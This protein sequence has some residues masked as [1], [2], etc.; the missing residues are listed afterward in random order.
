MKETLFGD[1]KIQNSS[2][3]SATERMIQ[4]IGKMIREGKILPGDRFP[5]ER[6]MA[7]QYNVSRGTVREALHYFETL[8]MVKKVTGSGSYLV[9]DPD[10]LYRVIGSRQLVERYNWMEM[11][12]TRRVLEVGIVHLAAERSTREDKLRLRRMCDE[13]CKVSADKSEAGRL[14][15]TELDYQLHREFARI[16]RNSILLE[17]F[18][19]IKDTFLRA[20]TVWEKS[21]GSVERGNESHL[22]ITKAIIAG[23]G[24]LASKEMQLHLDDMSKMVKSSLENK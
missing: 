17:M 1:L 14:Q 8:G 20:Q 23:D 6:L 2:F 9:D 11:I 15:Y 12:E 18:E 5:S 7:E 3:P 4:E 19:V 22:R 13:L 16:T 24:V 10:T 21:D